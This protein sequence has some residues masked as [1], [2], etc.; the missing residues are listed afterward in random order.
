MSNRISAMLLI[1]LMALCVIILMEA[2][3]GVPSADD[4]EATP[5][6][7]R[8]ETVTGPVRLTLPPLAS[9]GETVERPLFSET[10][11]PPETDSDDAPITPTP[12][13]TSTAG[14]FTVSAIV[15]TES[16]RAVLLVH[17]QSGELTRV[18]EGERVAGWRL[19][20]VDNDRAVFSK[21]GETREAALRTF[22]PAPPRSQQRPA[23]ARPGA[24]SPTRT[25]RRALSG[26]RLRPSAPQEEPASER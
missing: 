1:T 6:K 14:S 5:D 19:D 21:D 9:L 20:R 18:A 3:S 2:R 23:P 24:D 10:R 25:L 22:G 12:L 13:P 8:A 16:E 26:A 17:P 11:R 4:L 15:I 7:D